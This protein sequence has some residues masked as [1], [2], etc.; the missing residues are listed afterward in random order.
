LSPL[1]QAAEAA[2]LLALPEAPVPAGGSAQWF[3]GAGGR[4]LRVAYFPAETPVG[5][6]MISTGR[7]EA[8]EKYLEVVG[9]LLG[10]G[11]SVLVHDWRGQGLSDRLL[12]D[13]LKGH[14]VGFD[15]FVADFGALITAFADRLPHPRIA[16]AHSMGGCLVMLALA[17][18]EQRFDGAILSAPML[19]I[20]TGANPYWLARALAWAASALG[21]GGGYVLG[22]VTD[23]FT[24]TFEGDR[25]THD[26]ARHERSRAQILAS[27]DLALGNVTWGWAKSAFTAVDWLRTAKAVTQVAIPVTVVAAGEDTL[28]DNA[29]LKAVAARLPHG[30]FVEIPGA[31]HEI[32]ME[33]DD[34]RAVFWKEFDLLAATISPRA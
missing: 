18:G 27:R 20:Q 4:R 8:I 32:L 28:V 7:T 12:G 30:R 6:V 2:P 22:Q 16:M 10:R 14:A 26:P 23:P 24:A 11:F 5:S 1:L 3:V 31:Y 21:G 33:T 13:R 25:M 19:G 17:R 15:D 34:I 29:A 9:E